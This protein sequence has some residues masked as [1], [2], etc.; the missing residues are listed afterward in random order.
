MFDRVL[1]TI[2]LQ[3]S[4]ILFEPYSYFSLLRNNQ[5]LKSNNK[6]V[7]E[8]YF[9]QLHFLNVSYLKFLF[10]MDLAPNLYDYMRFPVRLWLPFVSLLESCR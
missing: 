8:I 3:F 2:L 7:L 10:I 6:P 1:N 4:Q 5:N 9:L